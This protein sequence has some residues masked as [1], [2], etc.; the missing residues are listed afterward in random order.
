MIQ[1]LFKDPDA[2]LRTRWPIDALVRIAPDH[3]HMGGYIGVVSCMFPRNGQI[4]VRVMKMGYTPTSWES[5]I[6]TYDCFG[7]WFYEDELLRFNQPEIEPSLGQL[8]FHQ[9]IEQ[10]VIKNPHSVWRQE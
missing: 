10:Y 2:E 6:Q 4:F 8:T 3:P 9:W 5:L 1:K 7:G